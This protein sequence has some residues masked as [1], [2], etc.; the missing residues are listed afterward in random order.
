VAA[1]HGIILN[2]VIL[3]WLLKKGMGLKQGEKIKIIYP[4]VIKNISKEVLR[5]ITPAEVEKE[6]FPG[7]TVEWFVDMFCK[8][9][10]GCTADTVVNR[11]EFKKY[12]PPLRQLHVCLA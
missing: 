3:L 5:H 7:K 1:L 10:K 4:I 11:I 2:P 6:D 9:H 12:E 8:S